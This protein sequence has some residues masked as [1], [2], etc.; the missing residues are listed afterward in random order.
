MSPM[1]LVVVAVSE[2]IMTTITVH[3]PVKVAT[4]RAALWAATLF[5]RLFDMLERQS[6][7]RAGRR[8][9]AERQAEAAAVRTYAMRFASHDPRF[10]ADLLAAAD[11]HERTD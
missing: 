5:M 11:R 10:T 9:V 4:P 6:A 7:A 8:I 3:T 1:P 2:P